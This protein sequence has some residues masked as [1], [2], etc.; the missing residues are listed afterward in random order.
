MRLERGPNPPQTCKA[1]V[2]VP[3]PDKMP[4]PGLGTLPVIAVSACA[5][6]EDRRRQTA[7]GANASLAKPIDLDLMLNQIGALLALEWQWQPL[8]PH[9]AD[10]GAGQVIAPPAG[11]MAVLH[12]LVQL[13]NMR[14][15]LERADYLGRLD[16]RYRPFAAQLRRL[17][18]GYQS[19]ALLQLVERHMQP[20]PAPVTQPEA[21]PASPPE[22]QPEP[23]PGATH[24]PVE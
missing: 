20:P 4:L 2:Y 5:G 7:A 6:D 9:R 24:V 17:A 21:Q 10:E 16:Q 15:I 13:G 3:P 11:E 8:P 18:H 23:S 1:E 19:L 12:R 22:S 14:D